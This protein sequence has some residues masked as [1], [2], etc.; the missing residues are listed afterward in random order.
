M[1]QQVAQSFVLAEFELANTGPDVTEPEALAKQPGLEWIP[2]IVP[3]GVHEALLAAGRLEH[4]YL[5]LNEGSARWVEDAVWWYRGRLEAPAGFRPDQRARLLFA[6]L[7]TVVTIWLNGEL[8]G[9]HVNQFR[10]AIFEV[11][12]RLRSD[13]ELV[14]RFA[15]PLAGLSAPAVAVETMERLAALFAAAAPEQA[16]PAPEQAAAALDEEPTGMLSNLAMTLR[17]KAT[18][19]WGWDFAPRLPSIGIAGPVEL[20]V[21]TGAML[22]GHYARATAVDA[23]ARSATVAVDL[24][25]DA[26]AHDG[27]LTAELTLTAPGGGRTVRTIPVAGGSA[28]TAIELEDAH[29]WWTHDLGTPDRYDVSIELRTA[30]GVVLDRVQDRIGLRTIALDRSPD[31]GGELFQFVLNGIPVFA[32]GANWVPADMMVGSVSPDTCRALVRKAREGNMTMLRVWGGGIY[33]QDAFYDACDE[34]GVLVWQDF[35]FACAPYPSDDPSLRAEVTAEAAYQVG[36]LRNHPSLA[37]W[38]GN[39]EVHMLHRFAYG[40]A[41]AGNWG[42]DFFHD[43]LPAAVT[44]LSPETPYWPGSPW[45][46]FS[47]INGVRGGDRHAWEVWHGFD[48]GAGGRTDYASRGEAMHFHRYAYDRGKFISEFGIHAAP[49]L[50]TLQRWTPGG[51]LTLD[52]PEFIHRNKDTPKDKGAD[53]LSVETGAP[54]TLE[55]YIDFSMAS[56]AEGLKFGVEHYRRRQPH[57]SGTLL[58]QLN[59]P[60]PGLS[61]SIIDH[62]LVPKAGYYYTQR[63]Y[64]PVLASFNRTED[65]GLELWLTSSLA[66]EVAVELRVEIVTFAGRHIVD[67][68]LH[69]AAPGLSS[70]AV[71]SAGADVVQGGPDRY[72]W[73]SDVA[74]A[75]EP[76]RLFFAPIKDLEIGAGRV[77]SVVTSGPDGVA[78]DLISSGYSY[79]TRV[80]APIAGLTFSSNYFDLRDGQRKRVEVTGAPADFDPTLLRTGTFTWR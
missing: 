13:N 42:Y 6:G 47:D 74:G 38:S 58:W 46:E 40:D 48:A 67:E 70:R 51:P 71:W 36:R 77:D 68:S 76:N 17:R 34:A 9:E 20:R 21:E 30:E 72:A 5:G 44:R 75:I 16:A 7:D 27:P 18:F 24:E 35:M 1:A 66:A 32:R 2:A 53:L 15:P 10:P 61:W 63:A 8:L 49:E 59:D 26:F 3:G 41:A 64:R 39:N 23:A 14:L 57:C 28:S 4:P 43:I 50:S 62:D 37:L 45:A 11:T 19:S 29:L 80:T 25:V 55:Q 22:T 31:E 52:G 12:H 79:F 54:Q 69:V 73:V 56:Q 78:V 60:W 65:G 33:E